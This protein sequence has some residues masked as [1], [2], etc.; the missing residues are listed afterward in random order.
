VIGAT[1]TFLSVLFRFPNAGGNSIWSEALS[2]EVLS[3]IY[4]AKLL[5]TEMK[6]EYWPERTNSR[7]KQ[8]KG[9]S[10]FIILQVLSCSLLL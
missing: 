5:K 1:N 8:K 3:T 7:K 9:V 6:L 10:R 4:G 2:F